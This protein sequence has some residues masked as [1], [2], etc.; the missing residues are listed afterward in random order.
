MSNIEKSAFTSRDIKTDNNNN[1]FDFRGLFTTRYVTPQIR[2]KDLNESYNLLENAITSLTIAKD[3]YLNDLSVDRVIPSR[4]LFENIFNVRKTYLYADFTLDKGT[5]EEKKIAFTCIVAMLK[6]FETLFGDY[7]SISKALKLISNL[8]KSVGVDNKI[9][10]EYKSYETCDY[11]ITYSNIVKL[12]YSITDKKL[13]LMY[14]IF[15]I[16]KDF[17]TNEMLYINDFDANSKCL[18]INLLPISY[19]WNSFENGNT[20]LLNVLLDYFECLNKLCRNDYFAE[21]GGGISIINALVYIENTFEENPTYDDCKDIFTEEEYNSL[22][23]YNKIYECLKK[24]FD[25]N[26]STTKYAK[27]LL[28]ELYKVFKASRYVNFILNNKDK[29]TD[30]GIKSYYLIK[31]FLDYYEPDKDNLTINIDDSKINNKDERIKAGMKYSTTFAGII[32]KQ[33]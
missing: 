23:R 30:S 12:C 10:D 26:V 27:P 33:K 7:E 32:E 6:S 24:D 5:E 8:I 18:T 11:D 4:V 20:K 9:L 25:N 19:F 16:N 21:D 22:S 1:Q 2:N 13:I 29:F 31:L 28:E 17:V 15:R 3:C 14:P